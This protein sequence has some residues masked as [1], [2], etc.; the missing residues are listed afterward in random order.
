MIF[1]TSPILR[2]RSLWP[3]GLVCLFL[4]LWF[5][6]LGERA[7]FH[8]DEGRYAEIP[9]EMVASGD[10]ITPRLN[11]LKYFEKPV[12]QYWITAL[13]FRLLGQEEGP[14]RLWPA[15]SGLLTLVLVYFSGRRLGGVRVGVAAA[16]ILASTFQFFLF[17][18]ILTLDMGLTFFLTLT[19]SAFLASQDKRGS[20]LQRR[21][22]ALLTWVA[23]GL[24]ILSKGLVGLVLPG[25]ILV[26]YI[27]I[28]RAWKLPGRLSWVRGAALLM[29]IVLPW[30]ILVQL[31]NPE[32]FQFFF[33]REHFSRYT[34]TEHQRLGAWY[35]F[36]GVF[37]IG[38]LP[39][40]F[41]YIRAIISSWRMASPDYFEINPSRLLVLWVVVI[42]LF[43]SLSSSKLP[44]YI[45]PIYPALALLLGYNVR[46]WELRLL[47]RY[48]V[49]M[50]ATGIAIA[51]AALT[52]VYLPKFAAEAGWMVPYVPWAVAG[53]LTLLT[54][55]LIAWMVLYRRRKLAMT[56]I[57][58][59]TLCA[60]QL[61]VTGAQSVARHFSSGAL[62]K[63]AKSTTGNFD[64]DVP[65]YSVGMYDQTLPWEIGRTVTL[66]SYQDE[67]AL[68]I[69][70]EPERAISSM[71]EFRERWLALPQ[72][73]AMITPEHFAAEQSRG[74]SMVVL[75]SNHKALIVARK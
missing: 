52:I 36:L 22:W 66:V 70:Q 25:L 60:F 64:P 20:P 39:W 17:S 9:R 28:E 18:Q 31:R 3:M 41:A 71:Q 46:Y 24:A 32:F 10:W 45:L 2:A 57:T 38:A 40:S 15:V 34:S 7:L 59:G 11:D 53:G 63:Q 73:Y 75:S 67:L 21:N 43:Y 49:G 5:G 56:L 13:T 33:V 14:A 55:S 12:L 27:I 30:F 4:I 6:T 48:L 44:G 68:G 26:A 65:F 54:A 74:T 47:S 8:P 69:S 58:I 37:L 23:M 42:T 19:L 62:V 29:V 35:Y 1:S 72:A 51:V 16:A 61:L 50:G